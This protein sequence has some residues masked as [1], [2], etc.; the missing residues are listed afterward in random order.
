[1]LT[2]KGVTWRQGPVTILEDIHLSVQSGE[3][4]M[5]VGPNGA[6]K[7]SLISAVAQGLPYVGSICWEGRDMKAFSA[8]EQAKRVGV[9]SQTQRIQD[10]FTVEEVVRL[11]RYAY[12]GGPLSGGDPLEEKK[13]KEALELTGLSDRA[14]QSVLTLSGGE[15]QRVALARVLA[16]DP[17]MLLLDEPGNHLD[18]AY[19][20]QL[21]ETVRGWLRTPGRAVLSVMHDLSVAR[22]FGSH[23][24]LLKAGR[25]VAQGACRAVLTRENLARAYG[26]DVLGWMEA[27]AK[28]WED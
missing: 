17:A 16:Q 24:L 25:A 11:G 22:A 7:T 15:L 2:L 19:Q 6:G 9:L 26:T 28:A 20:Q 5:L 27:V 10:A 14:G 4:W 23:A 21:V 8:K 12:R 1:M 18:L 3:W 13:I